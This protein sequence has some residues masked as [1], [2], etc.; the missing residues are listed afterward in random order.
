MCGRILLAGLFVILVVAVFVSHALGHLRG[1]SDADE[2]MM[3]NLSQA[4]LIYHR[5]MG[6]FLKENA[7]EQAIRLE[8]QY[9]KATEVGITNIEHTGVKGFVFANVKRKGAVH[10]E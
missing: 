9:G 10:E 4:V 6:S 1:V 5:E 2:K 8:Q 7:R 3:H